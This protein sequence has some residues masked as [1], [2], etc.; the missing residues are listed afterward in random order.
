MPYRL[1]P[2]NRR[3]VQVKRSGRWVVVKTHST[4]PDAEAHLAA[5]NIN[6][7]HRGKKKKRRK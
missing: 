7:H 4:V 3:Q 2:S 6:V 5:L 1:N